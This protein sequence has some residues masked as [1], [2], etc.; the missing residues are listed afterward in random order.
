MELLTL[1]ASFQPVELV[2]NYKSLIWTERYSG[3]GDFQITSNNVGELLDALPLESVVTLR[4]STVPMIVEAHKIEKKAREAPLITIVGRSFET[5]LERRASVNTLASAAVR[6]P[7]TLT[8]A[9]ESDAAYKAMRIVLGDIA[10]TQGG[11]TVLAAISPAISAN[12]AIPQIDLTL[13]VDYSTA[14]TNTY[15][16][17]PADLYHTVMELIET[18]H[19]GIK[20]VRPGVGGT[21]VGI[22]IYNGAD[23][24]STVVFNARF[25]QFDSSTYLLSAQGSSNVAYVYGSNGSQSVLKTAAPEPSGLDRRV[26]V[27]DNSSDANVNTTDIRRTRGLIELYKYNATALFDGEIAQQVAD[28]FNTQYFL[29]D[30]LQLNGEYG[31]TEQVRV[32]EYI[33]TSDATGEKAYPAFDAVS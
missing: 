4:E 30:I 19:H 27:L 8:A 32:A 16:I 29:G 24:T 13:P 11:P 33:R 3:A 6:T 22:E 2:E 17:K 5:V 10:R 21:Q 7:W 20:A 28:G 12:D 1:D 26:L 15:E 31:L 18:N 23:L 14:T 25:D 9:K